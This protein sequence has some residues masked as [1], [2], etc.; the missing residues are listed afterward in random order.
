M[1]RR[2]AAVVDSERV[3]LSFEFFFKLCEETFSNTFTSEIHANLT[4]KDAEIDKIK[5]NVF[6]TKVEWERQLQVCT[7]SRQ[8]TQCGRVATNGGCLALLLVQQRGCAR[9]RTNSG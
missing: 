1:L 5:D 4:D 9:L 7:T 2:L 8:T 6:A 3:V